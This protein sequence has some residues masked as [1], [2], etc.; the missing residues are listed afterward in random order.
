MARLRIMKQITLRPNVEK[1]RGLVGM[2]I[3][4]RHY[5]P[6]TGKEKLLIRVENYDKRRNRD[7]RWRGYC[8]AVYPNV[9]YI[10][11]EGSRFYRG[12]YKGN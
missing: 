6:N 5:V 11:F 8:G 12:K 10:V 7:K 1:R 2:K 3:T 4:F 9:G